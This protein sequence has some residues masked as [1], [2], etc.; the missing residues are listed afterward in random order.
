MWLKDAEGQDHEMWV[1][2]GPQAM[3]GISGRIVIAM[4]DS[5]T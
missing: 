3:G 5:K 1:L 4:S 2:G